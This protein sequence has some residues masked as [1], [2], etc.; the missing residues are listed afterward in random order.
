LCP[1]VAV[2]D[3]GCKRVLQAELRLVRSARL[4]L[5]RLWFE[6]DVDRARRDDRDKLTHL[7]C[8]EPQLRGGAEGAVAEV[9]RR[10]GLVGDPRRPPARTKI[11]ERRVEVGNATDERVE[12]AEAALDDVRRSLGPGRR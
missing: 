5:G 7:F 9:A 1:D 12:Q 6:D 10:V 8:R 2:D 11:A 3:Q 4:A